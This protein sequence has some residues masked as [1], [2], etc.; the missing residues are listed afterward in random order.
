MLL[1]LLLLIVGVPT[2]RLP[3]YTDYLVDKAGLLDS[4]AAAHIRQVAS[5][6]D[7]AGI[8]QL[9]VA[10]V[11]ESAL[12]DDSIEDYAVALFKKWGLGH[13]AKR[14][15]GLLVLFVPG[16]PGH[17]KIRIEVGYGLEGVL[18]DGKVGQ[19]RT[20]QA[21]PYMKNDDYSGAAVHVVDRIASL[22]QTD[23]AA[24]GDTAPTKDS[25]RGGKGIGQPG[26]AG[27][28]SAGGLVVTL[29]SM[30][31]LV[32]ALATSGSRRQFPGRKTQLAAAG[33]TG[34]SVLSLI[35]AGSGAGWLALVIGLILVAVIWT[36]IRA[37]RC[38]RDGSWMTID[39][40]VID[41]PTYWS[42]GVAHV[43]Q[44]CTNRK[45]NYRHEFD[46]AIPRKQMTVVTSGGGG[47]GGG[48]GGDGFS[49]GGGGRSG[50][51]GASG[52]V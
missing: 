44:Q 2:N 32:V 22:L 11:P 1:A 17:R 42:E 27:E 10:T 24:G 47:G 3:D 34:V 29:L 16:K 18:P 12:G 33:L 40:E 14:D 21:F 28:T 38:P 52:E 19:I 8:A 7:H 30:L 6:L 15:D 49:G 13:G 26:A 5:Q 25:M 31:A 51:G 37:H 39:E 43:I 9:A 36:S 48:G 4:A 46:K 50:G 41:P 20:E 23:A 35:A 45:C